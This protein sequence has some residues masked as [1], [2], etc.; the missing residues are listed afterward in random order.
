MFKKIMLG[1]IVIALLLFTATSC[2]GTPKGNPKESYS[3]KL[4]SLSLSSIY[5]VDRIDN[6]IAVLVSRTLKKTVYIK[7][8][9]FEFDICEGDRIIY[10]DGKIYRNS[11]KKL[12]KDIIKLQKELLEKDMR[13][14]LNI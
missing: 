9:D 5:D 2:W 8:N 11:N 14:S 4:P 6:G 13:L 7:V 10:M 3:K 1:K 12:K